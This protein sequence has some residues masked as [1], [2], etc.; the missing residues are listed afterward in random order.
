MVEKTES[1]WSIH[2]NAETAIDLNASGYMVIKGVKGKFSLKESASSYLKIGEK[3]IA[4]KPSISYSKI[5]GNYEVRMELNDKVTIPASTDFDVVVSGIMN[6]PENYLNVFLGMYEG[7]ENLQAY[8]SGN[9]QIV[10]VQPV[11]TIT[12]PPPT[13]VTLKA[14]KLSDPFVIK[15]DFTPLKGSEGRIVAALV[16]EN[17]EPIIDGSVSIFNKEKG[18]YSTQVEAAVVDGHAVFSELK[19]STLSNI[20]TKKIKIKFTD[21]YNFTVIPV[22]S[23]VITVTQE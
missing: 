6:P 11:I 9:V 2:M 1:K 17:E 8:A 19:F 18:M 23:E 13:A 7:K 15:V 14:D 21:L 22:Y 5:S 12:T 10:M 4:M 16:D 3:R 20:T